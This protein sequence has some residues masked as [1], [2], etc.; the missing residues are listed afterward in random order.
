MICGFSLNINA[1]MIRKGSWSQFAVENLGKNKNIT[2]EK[3]NLS[4]GVGDT[5][6]RVLS[7][8]S[9]T[10]SQWD[11]RF[12]LSR[13]ITNVPLLL[14]HCDGSPNKTD[15]SQL[16]R[17]LE[18]KQIKITNKPDKNIIDAEATLIDGRLM[19]Q[20]QNI[21]RHKCVLLKVSPLAWTI[22]VTFY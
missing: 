4:E 8:Q 17:C 19:V 7:I 5:F 16:T 11:L 20:W 1:H 3:N 6:A 14:A 10:A 2:E 21:S 12:L 18:E 22:H 13:P 15:K 9:V